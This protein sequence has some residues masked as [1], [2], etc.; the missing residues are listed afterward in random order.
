M[1]ADQ[2]YEILPYMVDSVVSCQHS[3]LRCSPCLLLNFGSYVR[4]D[5][6]WLN[7]VS[8]TGRGHL[9]IGDH[10]GSGSC[11]RGWLS[12]LFGLRTWNTC[13]LHVTVLAIETRKD[14]ADLKIYSCDRKACGSNGPASPIITTIH[15]KDNYLFSVSVTLHLSRT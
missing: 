9:K 4:I 1:G 5:V 8:N 12:I 15:Q 2:S 11:L 13:P 7:V 6:R 3:P 14:S 10:G